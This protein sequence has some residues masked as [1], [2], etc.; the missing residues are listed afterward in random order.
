MR[1]PWFLFASA[2]ALLLIMGAGFLVSP[3]DRPASQP[4]AVYTSLEIADVGS[5]ETLWLG[6]FMG[7]AILAVMAALVWMGVGKKG[8]LGVLGRWLGAGFVCLGLIFTALVTSYARYGAGDQDSFFGGLPAPTA[9]MLYGLWLFPMLMI[10]AGSIYFDRWYFTE[11]DQRS[12]E[13][14][15]R[16]ERVRKD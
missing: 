14:L 9:W 6:Y 15:M 11:E 4:H 3:S 5:Q 13:A 7:L 12:I 1:I 16:S 10:L 8:Q 2:S